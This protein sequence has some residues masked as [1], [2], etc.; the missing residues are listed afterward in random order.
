MWGF[1]RKGA[2][3]RCE[4]RQSFNLIMKGTGD[5]EVYRST[6]NLRWYGTPPTCD[7]LPIGMKNQIKCNSI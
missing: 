4:L 1:T 2:I 7:V 6:G 3:Y 5:T